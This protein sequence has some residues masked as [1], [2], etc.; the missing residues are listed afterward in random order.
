M[1]PK[2]TPVQGMDDPGTCEADLQAS[3]VEVLMGA[4]FP[5]GH[6]PVND[7]CTLTSKDMSMKEM[8]TY[9]KGIRQK[10]AR[11]EDDDKAVNDKHQTKLIGKGRSCSTWW[12]QR[13]QKPFWLK[14]FQFKTALLARVRLLL[15]CVVVHFQPRQFMGRN[16][17]WVLE[18]NLT[19][20]VWRTI[21][22]G[23]RP[24]SVTWG[25]NKSS[26]NVPRKKS[27]NPVPKKGKGKGQSK[28]AGPPVQS[29]AVPKPNLNPDEQL[30]AAQTHV[31]KLE[32]AIMA[33]GDEDLAV[34]GLKEALAKARAQAQLRPVQ[35]RIA[36]TEAFLDRSRKKMEALS[37]EVSRIQEV[38]A[39]LTI[40]IQDGTSR[41]EGLKAE[42]RVQPSPFTVPTDPQEE[43]RLLR[44][45]IAQMEGSMEGDVQE[46]KRVK[47]VP[48]HVRM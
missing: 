14:P 5:E 26:A 37:A 35:D 42:A 39:E 11:G 36:H 15:F 41:L 40:K 31:V 12:R 29:P 6:D 22:R 34:A 20:A 43:I 47:I 27:H 9:P 33:I 32:A 46:A 23:P 19:E 48:R 24:P 4:L 45:P 3:V 13:L 38:M 16:R 30:K 21:L 18:D 1:P 8:E 10:N 2:L 7:E 44:A 17:K 25:S 28:D